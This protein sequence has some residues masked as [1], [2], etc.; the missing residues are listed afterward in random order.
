M[1]EDLAEHLPPMRA[2]RSHP[3]RRWAL[4]LGAAITFLPPG[5]WSLCLDRAG[6]V[7][8]EPTAVGC[9]DHEANGASTGEACASTSHRECEDYVL[10]HGKLITISKLSFFHPESAAVEILTDLVPTPSGVSPPS[11][12]TRP[13]PSTSGA[14][15]IL[16]C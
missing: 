14:P 12:P 4:L 5:A 8:I 3:N 15:S 13:A 16:R 1:A 6:H 11:V 10:V 9:G 2:L 7:A